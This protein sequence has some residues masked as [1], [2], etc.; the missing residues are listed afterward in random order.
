MRYHRPLATLLNGLLD[1]G[2]TLERVAEPVPAPDW[3]R[4][5]PQAVRTSG[6]ALMFVLVR[7]SKA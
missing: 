1:A 6:G 2:L 5:R 4:S 3:V 7:A